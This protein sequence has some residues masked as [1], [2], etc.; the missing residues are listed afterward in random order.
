[1]KRIT[2]R[3]KPSREHQHAATFAPISLYWSQKAK[4][5]E[6][7]IMTAALHQCGGY[8][9]KA[10]IASF[11]PKSK[12]PH[13]NQKLLHRRP[14]SI[15]RRDRHRPSL[16]PRGPSQPPKTKSFRKANDVLHMLGTGIFHAAVQAPAKLWM[17]GFRSRRLKC[18]YNYSV[19]ELVVVSHSSL[20]V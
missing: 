11:R 12:V 7:Q 13:S 6:P 20:L 9:S 3:P 15:A 19:P 17:L 8:C 2:L 4:W 5:R 16:A 18:W 14:Q 10:S 1:M